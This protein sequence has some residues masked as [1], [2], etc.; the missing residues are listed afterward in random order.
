M[1]AQRYTVRSGARIAVVGLGAFAA[2]LFANNAVRALPWSLTGTASAG[3]A[4]STAGP[5]RPQSRTLVV[6]LEVAGGSGA[7]GSI[8]VSV[9]GATD[10]A[11]VAISLGGLRPGVTYVAQLHTGTREQPSASFGRLGETVADGSG[12]AT[13]VASEVRASAAG[14]P[15]ELS[16]GLLVDDEHLIV[17]LAPG[18]GPVASAI[19]PRAEPAAAR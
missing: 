12:R 19:L 18:A 16:P 17:I 3:D 9:N 1:I 4:G 10:Q 2:G 13:L 8:T 5:P 11:T 7:S 14:T 15:V 6:P